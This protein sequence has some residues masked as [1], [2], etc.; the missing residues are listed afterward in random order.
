MYVIEALGVTVRIRRVREGSGP[1]RPLVV[2]ETEEYP[3]DAI[4]CGN[5]STYGDI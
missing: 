5:E 2:V 4:V 3:L 1:N